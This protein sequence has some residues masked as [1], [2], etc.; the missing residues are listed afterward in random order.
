MGKSTKT[1]ALISE[2]L[3]LIIGTIWWIKTKDY[4]PLIVIIASI[5]AIV[6]SLIYFNKSSNNKDSTPNKVKIKQKA[7]KKSKQY[8]SGGDMTI[9]K[10]KKD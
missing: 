5:T 7:G 1:I 6:G 9:N 3:I 4:E 8:A 10:G 2:L